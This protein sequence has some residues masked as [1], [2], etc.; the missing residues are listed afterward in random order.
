MS[1]ALFPTNTV[2]ALIDLPPSFV[3]AWRT[4]RYGSIWV[5]LAG[6]LDL[7]VSAE[8][9]RMLHKTQARSNLVVLDLRELTFMDVAGA[10]VIADAGIS[11][12]RA[13]RG[14]L[15]ARGPTQVDRVFTLTGTSNQVELFDLDYERCSPVLN[16]GLARRPTRE[17]TRASWRNGGSSP[18]R[19]TAPRTH[20]SGEYSATPTLK[21]T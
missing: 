14:L 20:A 21:L 9:A 15:V 3:C 4:G 2:T 12:R 19:N 16:D 18:A 1:R 11:A 8:L 10:R 13:N 17:L 5:D 7:T 6:E